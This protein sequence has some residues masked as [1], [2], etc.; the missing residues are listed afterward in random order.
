MVSRPSYLVIHTRIFDRRPA[1]L[2][3]YMSQDLR[4]R[5]IRA[6]EGGMSRTAAAKRFGV[7]AASAVRWRQT[8]LRT[9]RS[10]AKSCG[11]DRR[12]GR[13]EAQVAR[14]VAHHD[15]FVAF[16]VPGRLFRYEAEPRPCG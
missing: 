2:A 3:A 6:I 13:L 16:A 4:I 12:S 1:A 8:Y 9:G 10:R 5:V 15:G 11:G 14:K 7:S